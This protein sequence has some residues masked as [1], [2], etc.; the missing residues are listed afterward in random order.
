MSEEIS[1]SSIL[2]DATPNKHGSK[3]RTGILNHLQKSL[4]RNHKG[5]SIN[6]SGNTPLGLS[7][8]RGG[9]EFS[10]SIPEGKTATGF[11]KKF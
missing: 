6:F 1:F 9:I 7:P 4:E 5:A 8:R 10:V 11:S 2:E 3:R